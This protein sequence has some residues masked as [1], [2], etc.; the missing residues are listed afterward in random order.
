MDCEQKINA[1][2][3]SFASSIPILAPETDCI[4]AETMGI[5]K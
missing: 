3:P 2:P 5:F 1:A 4:A